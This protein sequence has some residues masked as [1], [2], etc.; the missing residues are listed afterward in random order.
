MSEVSITALGDDAPAVVPTGGA[1][2]VT[3]GTGDV[4]IG[5]G[6]D[7]TGQPSGHVPTAQGDDTWEWAAGVGT[8]DMHS[9]VYDPRGITAD[10]FDLA[11]QTGRLDGGLFT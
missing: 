9:A 2:E 4:I 1:S 8:G 6:L 3:I 5:E 11:Q 10:V 7:A